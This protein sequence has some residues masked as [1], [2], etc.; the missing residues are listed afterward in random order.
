MAYLTFTGS[1][2]KNSC[3]KFIG[4]NTQEHS[5]NLISATVTFGVT[6][7]SFV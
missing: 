5:T 6:P 1:E 4:A 3:F 2:E 7:C